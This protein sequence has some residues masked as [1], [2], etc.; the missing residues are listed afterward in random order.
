[1]REL[2]RA[3]E[4]G[5]ARG[6]VGLTFDDGYEDFLRVATPVLERH[7][8]SATV[9]VV[10][11]MMGRE[12]DWKHHFEPRPRMKLL[13]VEGLREAAKRGMEV[14]A[15]SMSHPALS[16]LAPEVLEEE[17]GGSRRVLGEA[18]G[19]EVEGFCYPYGSI[20]G[21]AVK[22]V[23]EAGYAYA[24]S[25]WGRPERNDHDLPRVGVGDRDKAIRFAAKIARYKSPPGKRRIYSRTG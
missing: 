23:R 25:I 4:E 7:G 14:A 6:L 20:D 24:C 8:F 15:H 21:E 3:S 9:F 5:S 17:V 12:N 2:R 22:A 18:L 16:G 19:E 13:G 10:A 1:M 11:G